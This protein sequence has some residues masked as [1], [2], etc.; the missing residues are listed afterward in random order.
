MLARLIVSGVNQHLAHWFHPET[1]AALWM[2]EPFGFHSAMVK[3]H[4]AFINV[5]ELPVRRHLTHVHG[6]IRIGHLLFQGLLRAAP[7]AGRVENK[8]I[9]AVAIKRRKKRNALDMV[10]VKVGKKNMRG[11]GMPVL[12]L[13][14][15]LAQVAETGAAKKDVRVPVPA[16]PTA[17]VLAPK[18]LFSGWGGGLG[19]AH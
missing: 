15:L 7:A 12:L 3:L 1:K 8:R 18:A 2:V 10:P 11:N 13:H 9:F 19:P 5:G 6:K 4:A 16:A 17:G 14:K